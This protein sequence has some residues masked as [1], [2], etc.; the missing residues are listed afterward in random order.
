MNSA[1]IYID[2]ILIVT[3]GIKQ[4]HLKKVREV[5]KILD[6]ANIQLKAEKC[7]IA[8]YCIEWLGYRLSKTGISPINAK[9]QGIS[10]RLRPTNLKQLRSFL[11]AVN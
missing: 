8:K 1:F 11:G 5:M 9:S 7:V 4:E 6:E 3:K 10:D 2:D